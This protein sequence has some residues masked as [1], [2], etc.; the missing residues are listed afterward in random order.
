MAAVAGLFVMIGL[1]QLGT[2]IIK[3]ARI[4]KGTRE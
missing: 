4:I 2:D 3:A 1:F